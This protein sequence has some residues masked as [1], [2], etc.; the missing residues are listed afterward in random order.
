MKQK[1]TKQARFGC[2]ST[3]RDKPAL[4]GVW[5]DAMGAM[6]FSKSLKCVLLR[7]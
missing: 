2:L 1:P 6:S 7:V 4:V 3:R 5:S